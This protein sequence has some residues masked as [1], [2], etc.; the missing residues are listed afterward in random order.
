M[1]AAVVI[2]WSKVREAADITSI[3]AVPSTYK[4]FH[5]FPDEPKSN[6]SSP[7]GVIEPLTSI[8]PEIW[9]VTKL[10]ILAVPSIYKSFH[11]YTTKCRSITI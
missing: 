11:C 5:C 10:S 1:L 8:E 7:D 3:F 4:S 2:S 9:L 6:A